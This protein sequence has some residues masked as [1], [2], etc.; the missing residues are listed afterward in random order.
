M[1]NE[2]KK[3]IAHPVLDLVMRLLNVYLVAYFFSKG[4]Q[5]WNDSEFL[6]TIAFFG[7]A[8]VYIGF[9]F[10]WINKNY[11]FLRILMF[12]AIVISVVCL[13]LSKLLS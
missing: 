3:I 10:N 7:L 5:H 6:L 2:K 11:K 13:A 8:I 1:A 4:L 12:A 9:V